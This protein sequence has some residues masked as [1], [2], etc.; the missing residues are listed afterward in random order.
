MSLL[1][2]SGLTKRYPAFTLDGVSFG[3]DAGEIVGFIGRNGAGKTTTLKSLLGFVHPD[4]GSA[5][6]F[7]GAGEAEIKQRVGFVSGG[8][9]HYPKAKLRTIT[10]VTGH[11]QGKLIYD[12]DRV[13]RELFFQLFLKC[14]RCF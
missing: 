8:I 1:T 9:A 2:I 12:V 4:G 11:A 10:D 13:L 6:F 14:K 5:E 7:G 3:V